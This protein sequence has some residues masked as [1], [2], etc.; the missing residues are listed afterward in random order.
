MPGCETGSVRIVIVDDAALIR[1]A[2]TAF[3]QAA[4]HTVVATAAV[5]DEGVACA[6]QFG[7]DV[8]V[9]DGR[10]PPEGA[11]SFITRL[12]ATGYAAAIVVIAALD[13]TRLVRAAVA[14]GA[15]GALLRPILPGGV[16]AA[17]ANAGCIADA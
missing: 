11:V 7:P 3:A 15:T 9:V 10:L 6:M 17:L 4:G 8:V 1:A 16:A 14:A 13:E 2:V 5:A 12:R